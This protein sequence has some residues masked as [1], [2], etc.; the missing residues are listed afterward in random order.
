MPA[1]ARLSARKGR[2]PCPHASRPRMLWLGRRFAMLRPLNGDH[3]PSY[4][5][6]WQITPNWLLS[7]YSVQHPGRRDSNNN[8]LAK[9][10]DD[11]CLS[12]LSGT[13]PIRR[14]PTKIQQSQRASGCELETSPSPVGPREDLLGAI[15]VV[16]APSSLHFCMQASATERKWVLLRHLQPTS[17]AL[18]WTCS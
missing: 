13:E 7:G 14:R 18:P 11:H 16:S 15:R 1:P 12:L 3:G 5:V 8:S 2:S 17:L 9:H 10:G 6:V 4:V